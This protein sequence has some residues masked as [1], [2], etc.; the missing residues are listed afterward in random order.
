MSWYKNLADNSNKTENDDKKDFITKVVGVTF[1]NR[2]ETI[3]QVRA[4]QTILLIREPNNPYDSNAI[5]VRLENG[6]QLGYLK[7]ELAYKLSSRLDKISTPVRGRI[8]HITGGD[9]GKTLG[10]NITF[11]I[12]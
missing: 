7:R 12:K 6:E 9:M 10:V 3:R 5:S 1:E 4:G 11:T 8:L 2:Q